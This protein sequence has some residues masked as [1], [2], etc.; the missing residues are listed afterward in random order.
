MKLIKETDVLVYNLMKFKVVYLNSVLKMHMN[1]KSLN[2]YKR[3]N[4]DF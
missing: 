2:K 4:V 3:Y 1:L